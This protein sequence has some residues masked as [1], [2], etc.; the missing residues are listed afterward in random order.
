MPKAR[1]SKRSVD[2]LVCPSD[3]DREFLWDNAIAGFGVVAFP[4]GKKSYLAQFRH[5]GR[6]RRSV[7]GDHGRLTPDEARSAAK[8]LLGA[9]E[10][11]FDPI[12][13]K[14]VQRSVPTFSEI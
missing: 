12:A 5:A 6:S 3:K 4:S 2:A 9:V 8:R 10:Q 11:G 1:I 14:R 13:A 7:I